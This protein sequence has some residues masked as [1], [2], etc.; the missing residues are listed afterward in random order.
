VTCVYSH[1]FYTE[2]FQ[3]F[4]INHL[5]LAKERS[6]YQVFLLY[7]IL[8]SWCVCAKRNS[9]SFAIFYLTYIQLGHSFGFYPIQ[10][11]IILDQKGMRNNPVHLDLDLDLDLKK[12]KSKNKEVVA[13]ANQLSMK[14][15]FQLDLESSYLLFLSSL[16]RQEW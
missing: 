9:G 5:C 13:R 16:F 14:D 2:Q 10:I 11:F 8:R 1:K 3:I 15:F 6:L 7:D 12:N 4:D